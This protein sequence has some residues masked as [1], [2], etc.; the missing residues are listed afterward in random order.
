MDCKINWT[1][2]AWLSFEENIFYLQQN[3]TTAE[4]SKFVTMVENKILTLTKY[5]K[6]GTQKSTKFPNIRATIIHKKIL[7]IYKYKPMKNEIDLLIFW[8]TRQNPRK[9]SFK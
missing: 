5:P 6:I 7:L 9:L 4:V 2:K 3:W 8:N 1:K